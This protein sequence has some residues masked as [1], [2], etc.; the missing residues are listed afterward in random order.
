MYIGCVV[1]INRNRLHKYIVGHAV[2][3]NRN[4]LHK[5]DEGTYLA[6]L[7]YIFRSEVHSIYI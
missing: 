2:A 1:A 6:Y 3:I 4:R 5:Q 7:C